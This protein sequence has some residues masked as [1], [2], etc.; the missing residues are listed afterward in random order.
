VLYWTERTF[1]IKCLARRQTDVERTPRVIEW[2]LICNFF[3]VFMFLAKKCVF[4]LSIYC[5]CIYFSADIWSTRG[6]EKGHGPFL[7]ISFNLWGGAIIIF[8][9]IIICS[10]YSKL[11]IFLMRSLEGT[12]SNFRALRYPLGREC[13]R[14]RSVLIMKQPRGLESS[15]VIITC[16]RAV[17]W[18]IWYMIHFPKKR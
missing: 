5:M 1:L 13:F 2:I 9:I 18:L 7:T 8:I 16:G 15:R 17:R 12:H 14:F 10:L 3:S 4:F 6:K 11:C